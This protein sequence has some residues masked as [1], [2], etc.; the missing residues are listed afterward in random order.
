MPAQRD[1]YEVLGLRRDATEAE[2]KT[3]YRDLARRLHPDVARGEEKAAAESRMKELNEAYAVLSDPQR[4]AHYDRFGIV[5]GRIGDFG[6]GGF[7]GF[8]DIFDTFF[9]GAA[10]APRAAP[11]RGADLRY[12]LE[13]DLE[14]VLRG[15]ER[16]I[17]FSA[18]SPCDAC[19]GS[20]AADASGQT[21]CP[22]CRGYGEVRATRSTIFGHFTTVTA[23]PRCAGSG[24]II[25]NPCKT[26]RGRGSREMQRRITVK[27]PPGVED[28]TR[29]RYAG[30]GEAG[31]RGGPSGDLYV[32]LTVHPHDVFEREGANLHCAT[33]A[34]FT[35]AALG[36]DIEIDALDGPVK[37]TL[38]PGTQ[39]GTIFRVAGRGLPRVRG[40]GR[41]DLLVEMRVRVPT[42]LTRKQRELLEAFARAGGDQLEE[43]NFFRKVTEAFGRD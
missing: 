21:A 38:H 24:R 37:L 31:Q 34:S 15:A 8:S 25:T 39:T 32:Y 29:L 40:G 5:E 42:K 19:K 35:Q 28:G 7:P 22:D 18:V 10:T 1:F 13:I 2:I 6:F 20:G 17:A 12:D 23:C 30:L 43:K 27:I 14:D 36:A 26:C 9:G 41:G 16:E 4:R 11:V 33:D 3:A